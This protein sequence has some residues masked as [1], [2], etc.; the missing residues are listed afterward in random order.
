MPYQP[1]S[2]HW[3]AQYFSATN[4]CRR[5][6]LL[7]ATDEVNGP[8]TS[9]KRGLAWLRRVQKVSIFVIPREARNLSVIEG[10]EKRDS[11]LRSE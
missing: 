6:I 8:W 1:E 3:L 4:F 11:S 2:R 7:R 10:P 5:K 9:K